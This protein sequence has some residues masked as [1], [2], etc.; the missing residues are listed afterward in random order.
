MVQ[1]I[2]S[3][4]KTLHSILSTKKE[5]IFESWGSDSRATVLAWHV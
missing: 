5:N 2:V 3:V 4:Q 1:H